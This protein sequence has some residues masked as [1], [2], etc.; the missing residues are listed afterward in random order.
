M[1]N[2]LQNI[3]SFILQYNTYFDRGFS[4]AYQS[5][6]GVQDGATVL[7]PNDALGDY[8]Y[9]RPSPAL[10]I[11]TNEQG[12]VTDCAVPAALNAQVNLIAVVRNADSV[13]L[14]NNLITTLSQYQL[15]IGSVIMQSEEVIQQELGRMDR[16]QIDATLQR[17][18]PNT[19]IIAIA[20]TARI[21]L[22]FIKIDCLPNPCS[23]CG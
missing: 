6:N 9:L 18:Q 2:Y 16:E 1:N 5:A 10:S 7:M 13:L 4:N 17:L 3:A 22:P 12:R 20:F 11:T 14:A 15:P 21:S 19:K 8:F 23:A